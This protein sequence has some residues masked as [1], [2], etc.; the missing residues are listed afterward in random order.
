MHIFERFYRGDKSR[1]RG[2]G[3]GLG[4]SICQ[5]VVEAHNG[6]LE[7]ESLPGEGARFT[8]SL[9]SAVAPPENQATGAPTDDPAASG[10]LA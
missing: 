5:A 7:V 2:P 9:P 1:S 8:V 10:A 4:L 3:S 6:R